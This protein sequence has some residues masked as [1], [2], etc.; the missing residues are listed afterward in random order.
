[1]YQH[2]QYSAR[3]IYM[4]MGLSAI[5]L[6]LSVLLFNK[7]PQD[8][9]IQVIDWFGYS[10]LTIISLLTFVSVFS[11]IKM[12]QCPP[13]RMI[14]WR[15]CALHHANGIN[16]IALTFT[17]LGISLGIS[18]LAEQQLTPQTIQTIIGGLTA[19]FSV[20][21]MTTVLGLP[22]SAGLK[23]WILLRLSNHVTQHPQI[24]N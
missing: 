6:A 8:I 23:S 11:A 13:Q 3:I 9:V 20:A 24:T 12:L 19:H 1:M 10:F 16:T 15:D 18:T 7:T 17:L 5:T 2:I 14:F 22:L 21:F 4:I